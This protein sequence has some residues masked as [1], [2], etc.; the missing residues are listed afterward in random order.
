MTTLLLTDSETTALIADLKAFGSMTADTNLSAGIATFTLCGDV[1][2]MA[3]RKGA[4]GQP[5]I[6]RADRRLLA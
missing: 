6:I 3:L 2:F 4:V 5:W 1:V